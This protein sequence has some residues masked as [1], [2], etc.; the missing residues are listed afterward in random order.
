M[1]SRSMLP[2][3]RQLQRTTII[4]K[5]TN[6]DVFGHWRLNGGMC[7]LLVLFVTHG[8]NFTAYDLMRWY[9]HAATI[10]KKRD[11]QHGSADVRAAAK[12]R[13]RNYCNCGYT[14]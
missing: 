10:V 4:A 1:L 6:P 2:A 14:K 5:A 11:R 3:V 13:K 12:E 8:E 7:S 9:V